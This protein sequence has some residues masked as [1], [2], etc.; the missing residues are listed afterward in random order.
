M[1]GLSPRSWYPAPKAAEHSE[2]ECGTRAHGRAGGSQFWRLVR[3]VSGNAAAA[4]AVFQFH[5]PS[6]LVSLDL[7][8][9]LLTSKPP[10]PL[11]L[12]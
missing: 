3:I 7:R 9:P 6:Q 10:C 2:S 4:A 12:V 5:F 8:L 11:P 1:H